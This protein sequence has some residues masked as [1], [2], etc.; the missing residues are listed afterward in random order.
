ME[1]DRRQRVDDVAE[2]TRLDDQDGIDREISEPLRITHRDL[3]TE[4]QSIG[5]AFR[6]AGLEDFLLRGVDIVFYAPLLDHILLGMINAIGGTPIAVARLADAAGVDEIFFRRLNRDLLDLQPLHAVIAHEG[7]RDMGVPEKTNRR[8][9]ISE[10]GDGVE[11]VEDVAPLAGSIECGV[12]DG[13]IA[14]LPRESQIA[15]PFLVRLGQIFARPFDR[16]FGQLIKIAVGG[17]SERRLFVVI[18]LD[19]GTIQLAD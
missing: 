16:V 1:R 8:V 2:R 7:D 17:S 15:Q 3:T 5:Q 19:H 12:H 11:I 10:A 18:S 13:E 6:Q 4:G 9:L 14:H